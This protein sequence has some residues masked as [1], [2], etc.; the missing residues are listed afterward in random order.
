MLKFL[1]IILVFCNFSAIYGLDLPVSRISDDSILRHSLRDSWFVDTPRS[2]LSQFGGIEYL[3]TGE[4]VEVKA[5][6]GRDE[7]IV[8]LSREQMSGRVATDTAPASSRRPTGQFPGWAQ[9]SWMLTRNKTTGAPS[10]IRIF[11]R[12]DQF[13]YVQFRPFNSDKCMM[14]VVLYGAYI[15]RSVPVALPFSRLYTMPI[16]DVLKLV[17]EK[18]SLRYFEPDPA[19]YNDSRTFITNVRRHLGSLRY[20]D[21]GAIDENG[22]Y[23]FINT[24][25]R[26]NPATAGLNCSGFTKWLIDGILRPVT[27]ER[28]P[29]KPLSAPFGQRGSSFT[30]NWE[31][32]RDVFFGLDWIRNLAA[33]ANG[34]L[35]SPAFR[36]LEEFEV[37]RDMFTHYIFNDNGVF[38]DRSYHGFMNEAGYGVEGLRPLL[39][40]LAVDEPYSFYLAAVN[41]EISTPTSRTGTPRLRQYYHVAAL[42]PY[43]DEFGVFRIVVFES[44]EETTF[45]SFRN[46]YPGQFV[47]LVKVPVPAKFEP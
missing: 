47:S 42:V 34:T 37:R 45:N 13:A 30:V 15:A 12:S 4:R 26:Q 43:F 33:E 32:R 9:G 19:I 21:D 35:R 28:L 31:E 41:N 38:V 29:V 36:A 5:V 8:L 25:Q 18:V 3:P 1:V 17:E 22:N 11:L 23:V 2:V 40:T 10:L 16:N 7:F 46:R 14:D 39:Y 20:A 6:E 24:L 44:A 27:G